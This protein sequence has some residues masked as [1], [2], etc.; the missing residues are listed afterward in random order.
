MKRAEKALLVLFVAALVMFAAALVIPHQARADVAQGFGTV[1]AVQCSNVAPTLVATHLVNSRI[2][3]SLIN[4]G[5][6]TIYFGY[7]NALTAANGWPLAP[8]ATIGIDLGVNVSLYC[9]A[10]SALQASPLDTRFMELK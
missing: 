1:N 10:T 9:L 5:P 7:S 4:L 8:G 6:N 3:A 2:N